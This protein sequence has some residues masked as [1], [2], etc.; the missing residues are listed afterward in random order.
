LGGLS[1]PDN[2]QHFD[3]NLIIMRKKRKVV[4]PKI[5]PLMLKQ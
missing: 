1:T 5:P 3:V 2:Q 4:P